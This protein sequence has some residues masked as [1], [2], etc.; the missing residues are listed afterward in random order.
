MGREANCRCE[1]NGKAVQVK[2][3]IEPPEL[4][5]RGGIRRRIPFT[6]LTGVAAKGSELHFRVGKDRVC[7]A[8]GEKVAAKWATALV[9]EP[10][11]L[12]KKLGVNPGS[13]VRVIGV[14]DDDALRDALSQARIVRSGIADVIV[15]RVSTA[16][17]LA[18]AFIKAGDLLG[19]G[20]PIWIV[21]KKGRGQEIG[22]SDVRSAGLAAGIVDVKVASVSAQLTGLKF[23]MRKNPPKSQFQK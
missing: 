19:S 8:L 15:A 10:P 21:Y 3:L 20:V 12:A 6:E 18:G 11:S 16:L 23:V 1:W 17:E 9:I 14:V 5:L 13:A 22:E 7:L 4:I 2:A